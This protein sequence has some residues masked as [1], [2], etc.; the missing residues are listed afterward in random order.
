[1]GR[2]QARHLIKRRRCAGCAPV[3]V[4][5]ATA[6]WIAH[7][8]AQAATHVV[9]P[10]ETL[11][12]IAAR[13]GTTVHA[14]ARAN[15]LADPDVIVAGA[16]LR[17][18]GPVRVTSI[19]VVRPGETLSQIAARY[20]TT[21]HA[22][23][24]ANHLADPDVIV[25][26]R[27][28]RVPHRA[29]TEAP[30]S[31]GAAATATHVVRPGETLSQ[32]AARYGTT[33]RAL[34][35]AN[36][37]ADPDVIVA[38]RRLRVPRA[39]AAPR[40]ASRTEVGAVLRAEAARSGVPADLVE[41]VAWH[42]SGWNQSAVSSAGAVGVMQVMRSTTAYVNRVLGGGH[43][44]RHRLRDNI[45]IGTMYLRHLLGILPERKALA[46]YF[47]GPGNVGHRLTRSQRHYVDSV[48]AL[49]ARM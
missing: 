17:V 23:A 36:H 49:R 18:P 25:A 32:I 33:V 6:V 16:R 8:V 2:Y 21:V 48:E 45:R 5:A 7:P 28:L 37:L 13:Y 11:S 9:R 41:A 31:D 47:S 15:H 3:A 46:A 35:R 10:G 1:M 29:G 19:H 43:L 34:V 42:E 44:R 40:A 20:G 26:G 14:L 22:L 24:R 12:Q 4:G 39:F 38:G 30:A 27:H